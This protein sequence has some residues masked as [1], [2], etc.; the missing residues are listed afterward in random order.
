MTNLQLEADVP[1][2]TLRRRNVRP[3]TVT[4][5]YGRAAKCYQAPPG[6]APGSA[7]LTSDCER[8]S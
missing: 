2:A 6:L 1:C 5:A 3:A 8:G 4:A 7:H